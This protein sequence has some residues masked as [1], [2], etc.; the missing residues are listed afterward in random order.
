M[1]IPAMGSAMAST[2]DTRMMNQPSCPKACVM[3][4]QRAVVQ[5]LSAMPK[6]ICTTPI[7]SA[8]EKNFPWK[9]RNGTVGNHSDME[10][11]KNEP[12][13]PPKTIVMMPHNVANHAA[14]RIMPGLR[15]FESIH[16]P[17]S[18][19]IAPYPAS[20]RQMPKKSM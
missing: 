1:V 5:M 18:V 13:I 16:A 2:H 10:M 12:Q 8:M 6:R 17:S 20:F 15:F 7:A 19:R 3:P 14:W 4:K 9:S 11:P